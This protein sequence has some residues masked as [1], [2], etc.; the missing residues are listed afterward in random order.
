MIIIRILLN[1]V[2][3]AAEIAAVAGIAMLGYYHP[4]LFAGVTA[5]LSFV[6]GLRL[7]TKRLFFELPFYFEGARTPRILLVGLV[8][9]VEALMKG[10]LAGLAAVFTFAGTDSNRLLWVAVVF[11]LTTYAGSSALRALSVSFRAQPWR[12]GYFRLAP[13]LGLAFSAGIAALAAFGILGTASVGDIGWK[14]VWELPQKP[15]V[16]QVSELF[17]Q[18]KQAFDDF[19]VTLL[20]AVMG[21]EWAR[22]IGIV[23]SVNVLTGFVASVYAAVIAACVRTAEE[24][25]P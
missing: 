18:L 24:G 21:Q 6:L 25:L 7:E 13:P 20:T 17:F 15:S 5:A 10:V 16:S 23:I 22:L 19:I 14:L 8:G 2:I 1:A 11:G 12:W 4:F 9:T 3:M